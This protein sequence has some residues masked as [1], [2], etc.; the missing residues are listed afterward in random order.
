MFFLIPVCL[1]FGGQ[2]YEPPLRVAQPDSIVA[3][4]E[5]NDVP[6][7]EALQKLIELSRSEIIFNDDLV[8]DLSVSG[9]FIKRSTREI[10]E[11]LL[12][13]TGLT[14]KIMSRGEFVIIKSLT[15]K[16][17]NLKGFILDSKSN[18]KL[19]YANVTVKN[20]NYGA[21][22]NAHG[23]FT[24]VNIPQ[25]NCILKIH[26]LGYEDIEYPVENSDQEEILYV[27]M[28]Q[29]TLLGQEVV[30]TDQYS[31]DIELGNLPSQ[32]RISPAMVSGLPSLGE[33]DLFRTLQ[34]LP[35]ISSISGSSSGLSVRGG[36]ADQNL[37]LFD[38]IPI[39]NSDHFFGFVSTFN[40]E[41]IKDVSVFK[42]GFPAKFGNKISSVIELTGK[43]GNTQNF[44]AGLG[45]NLLSLSGDI[46]I[47]VNGR[48]AFL[49]SFR[50]SYTDIFTNYLY[51]DIIST[52]DRQGL[53]G[54]STVNLNYMGSDNTASAKNENIQIKPEFYYFDFNSKFN[55]L[56][57]NNDIFS[58]SLYRSYDRSD[59][60]Q[61][62]TFR[63]VVDHMITAFTFLNDVTEWGNTGLS[64]KWS[65]IWNDF[66]FTDFQIAYSL[67]DSESITNSKEVN[68]A[69]SQFSLDN[70][71]E[72]NRVRNLSLRL[73]NQYQLNDKNRIEFGAELTKTNIDLTFTTKDTLKTLDRKDG[74]S[75]ASFYLQNSMRLY[76]PLEVTAGLRSTYYEATGELY[77]EPRISFGLKLSEKFSLKGAWGNYYQFVNR[78]TNNNYFQGNRDFW[79]LADEKLNPSFAQHYI[80]G[81]TYENKNYL[82][83]TEIYY[84]D[85]ESIAVFDQPFR[86]IV[87]TSV[88]A[89]FYL[90][91]GFAKGIEFIIQKKTGA[92]NGWISYTLSNVE[93]TIPQLNQGN[94]FP[95]DYN[96]THQLNFVSSYH[97]GKCSFTTSWIYSTGIPF[98]KS[99]G[100][101]TNIENRNLITL[102]GIRGLNESQLPD[103]HRLDINLEYLFNFGGLDWTIGFSIYNL[104]NRE[105]IIGRQN[106]DIAGVSRIRDI[107]EIGIT[108]TFNIQ[109]RY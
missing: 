14:F 37:I 103:Y 99:T 39:Y 21:A 59:Q 70:F 108:P 104:Y 38:G 83:N 45:I 86:R 58:L 51:D 43:S 61:T 71:Y 60:S 89:L 6:L 64:A 107:V 22:A 87:A 46:Q 47:P 79:L 67:Y 100:I 25:E 27:K 78:I 5:L 12:K 66:L 101:N 24:L 62:L 92:L 63:P 10:L 105:N 65:R 48:G 29:K 88:P 23:Y 35:G 55:Y 52:L 84:K 32:I 95:A 56:V 81:L 76:K 49:L 2:G 42:G 13:D 28:R 72:K 102:R 54:N 11:E 26:Y 57:T 80:L 97:L 98:T 75:L 77:F 50:R 17:M 3:N 96:R 73:D 82:F 40:T 36:T 8:K 16:F 53:L 106:I 7:G 34:L 19:P 15:K 90:G 91:D 1:L 74:A 85:L 93:Y 4:F 31:Q 9:Q 94:S 109:I 41:A 69:D 33:I 20:S 18:E 30:V 44:Q 68:I